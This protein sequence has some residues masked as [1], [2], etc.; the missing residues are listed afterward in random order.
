MSTV[1]TTSQL[2]ALKIIDAQIQEKNL[3]MKAIGDEK[4]AQFKIISKEINN[5]LMAIKDEYIA[6]IQKVSSQFDA[7]I[8]AL[9]S[10]RNDIEKQLFGRV[11][12]GTVIQ[13][14]D[15]YNMVAT[16]VKDITSKDVIEDA[17]QETN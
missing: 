6:E 2:E 3:Q 4:E 12:S 15:V 14:Y 16:I 17:V 11:Y 9:T 8:A 1:T 5:K 13:A 10:Q 7:E